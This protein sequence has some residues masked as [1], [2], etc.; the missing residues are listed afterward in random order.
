M[1]VKDFF[2]LLIHAILA[3]FGVS[4]RELRYKDTRKFKVARLISNAIVASFGATIVY[5]ISSMSG[6]PP[7]M[8]YITAGLVG[9]GGPQVIDRLFEKN[10]EIAKETIEPVKDENSPSHE[11]PGSD[12]KEDEPQT[13]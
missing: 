5:F 10:V 2:E 7:Q 11:S 8:G 12:A 6:L 13:P 1:N 9:W 4:A 3:I